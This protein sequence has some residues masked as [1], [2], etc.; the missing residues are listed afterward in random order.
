[1]SSAC[2]GSFKISEI[3]LQKAPSE[4]CYIWKLSKDETCLVKLTEKC[5]VAGIIN[6]WD[7]ELAALKK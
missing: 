7:N 5:E 4:N 1:M 6:W 2:E 3:K